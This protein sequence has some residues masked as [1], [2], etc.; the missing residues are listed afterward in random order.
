MREVGFAA[1]NQSAGENVAWAFGAFFDSIS[2]VAKERVDDNQGMRLRRAY[3][4]D[5]LL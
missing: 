2:P 3:D 5:P 1:Y 4:L